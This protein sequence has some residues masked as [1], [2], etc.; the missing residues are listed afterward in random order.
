MESQNRMYMRIV[1]VDSTQPPTL[2]YEYSAHG[3]TYET[4]AER[5]DN[6][7][8]H[9]QQQAD[10][11]VF[12]SHFDLADADLMR[13]QRLFLTLNIPVGSRLVIDRDLQRHVSDLPFNQ[14]EDRARYA[15]GSR[16]DKTEWIMLDSGLKCTAVAADTAV[17]EN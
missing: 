2:T 1:R 8:Y 9:F 14:C 13:D 10:R 11:L 17:I 16:P 6:I 12:D 15:D 7:D 4:A 5:A 3:G